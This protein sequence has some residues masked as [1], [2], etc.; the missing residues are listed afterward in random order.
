MEVTN[1]RLYISIKDAITKIAKFTHPDL[2]HP[3]SLISDASDIA[4]GAVIR[5]YTND[6][7]K[8][9]AFLSKRF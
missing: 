3:I 2:S 4:V 5:Q 8:L 9:S 7:W 6:S 1:R